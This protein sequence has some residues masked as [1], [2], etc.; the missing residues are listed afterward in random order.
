MNNTTHSCQAGYGHSLGVA[1]SGDWGLGHLVC[2]PLWTNHT[3]LKAHLRCYVP[4]PLFPAHWSLWI[5][6]AGTSGRGNRIHVT[7]DA[8]N[9]FQHDFDPWFN[10]KT[11]DG[12]PKVINLGFIAAS[13]LPPVETLASVCTELLGT[14]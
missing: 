11:D 10:S 4:S 13:S 9:G 1:V 5:A 3:R 6:Y 8:L 12:H 7:G 14:A 2:G